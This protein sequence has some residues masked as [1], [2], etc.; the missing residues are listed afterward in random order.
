MF[1]FASSGWKPLALGIVKMSA[2]TLV[3]GAWVLGMTI[4]TVVLIKNAKTV[5][6]EN[7]TR[8]AGVQCLK[9]TGQEDPNQIAL[10]I[11]SCYRRPAVVSLTQSRTV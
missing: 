1:P 5:P 4:E 3:L 10:D 8:S 6:A 7:W 2:K 9:Q 11:V